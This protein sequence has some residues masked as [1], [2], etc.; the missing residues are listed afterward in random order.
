[1]RLL[2]IGVS[3]WDDAPV[4][5]GLFDDADEAGA[6]EARGRLSEATDALRRRF[7]AAA[8][9]YGSELKF[10]DGVSATPTTH[11]RAE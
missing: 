4:Q 11:R 2:G 9:M 10:R 8:A 6:E 1:M 7:G 3:N 5:L